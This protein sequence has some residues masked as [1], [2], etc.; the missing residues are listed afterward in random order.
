MAKKKTARSPQKKQGLADQ[1]D[2]QLANSAYRKVMA[3]EQPTAQEKAALKRYEKEQ[4]ETRRWQYYESIPQ[5]HWRQ[6]SGRQTK[7]LN[8]QAERYGIPFGGRTINL[9]QVVHAL[10]DFLA[11][12]ARKFIDDDDDLLNANVSSPAL[13]RY[14]EERAKL[15]KLD[16]LEREQRLVSR[17]EIRQGLGQIAGILRTAGDVLQ[18]Q[19]GNGAVEILNEAL[20]DAVDAI[21]QLCGAENIEPAEDHE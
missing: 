12:N 18:R 10:H 19:Y 15:A 17:D 21:S 11:A 2:R 3:G 1:L 4:E 20:D 8:E 16:R 14:R 6:M 13:E 9:P 5:K 7:V